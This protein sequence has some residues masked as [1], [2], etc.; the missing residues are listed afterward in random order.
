[1]KSSGT[2]VGWG[3]SRRAL[4][5]LTLFKTKNCLFCHP[6]KDKRPNFTTLIHFV[7]HKEFRGAFY[8]NIMKLEF[9]LKYIVGTS[10][11]RPRIASLC[12]Q[13]EKIRC[14]RLKL[15]N[16]YY[17]ENHTLFGFGQIRESSALLKRKSYCAFCCPA[18]NDICTIDVK[19]LSI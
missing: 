10:A 5:A 13:S 15:V 16:L 17:P 1:M 11:C 19:C 6:V 4:Q 8:I 3:R 7:L 9:F 18:Q 14:S 2:G 12:F